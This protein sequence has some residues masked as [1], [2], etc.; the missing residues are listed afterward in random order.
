MLNNAFGFSFR[1]VAWTE[2]G[3]YFMT[4][5]Y[6][7][8]SLDHVMLLSYVILYCSI[9][10]CVKDGLVHHSCQQWLIAK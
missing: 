9:G 10:W 6:N 1:V 5:P 4:V 3:L 8:S 7:T 2:K